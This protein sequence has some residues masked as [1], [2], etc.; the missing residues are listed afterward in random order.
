[1]HYSA[2]IIT[3]RRIAPSVQLKV[4]HPWYEPILATM[5]PKSV[6]EFEKMR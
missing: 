4:K 2:D 6:P 5:R 3:L 1:M